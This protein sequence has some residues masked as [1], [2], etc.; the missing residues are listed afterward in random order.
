MIGEGRQATVPQENKGSFSQMVFFCKENTQ[1]PPP[2]DLPGSVR[3]P[4]TVPGRRAHRGGKGS[5][6]DTSLRPRKATLGSLPSAD[7]RLSWGRAVLL[8][9]QAFQ[10]ARHTHTHSHTHLFLSAMLLRKKRPTQLIS[11]FTSK[12]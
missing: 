3:S 12:N 2:T 6:W 4:G 7:L 5:G 11:F 8:F 9:P 10:H 1:L